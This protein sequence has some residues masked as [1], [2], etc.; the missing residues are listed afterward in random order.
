MIRKIRK[1]KIIESGVE[2]PGVLVGLICKNSEIFGVKN[3]RF[4]L[5]N[6]K[7]GGSNPPPAIQPQ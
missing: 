6:P 7:V 4:L 1:Y 3:L 2:Q 5:C